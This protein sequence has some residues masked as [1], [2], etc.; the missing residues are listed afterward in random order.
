[1]GIDKKPY[2]ITP[3]RVKL[4]TGCQHWHDCFTC[5]FPDCIEGVPL[6]VV[7]RHKKIT[8]LLELGLR[9]KDI[10]KQLDITERTVQ[11]HKHQKKYSDKQQGEAGN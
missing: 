5:P 10:A 7:A 6:D 8:E 3:E 1:M 11:R 9:I 2:D 4:G